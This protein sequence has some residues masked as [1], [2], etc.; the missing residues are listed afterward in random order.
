MKVTV[1]MRGNAMVVMLGG[2]IDHHSAEEIRTKI[3]NALRKS[4]T[5]ELI[6]NFADVSFMDS[7]GLGV[8][9]GRYKKVKAMGGVLRVEDVPKRIERI[10]RMAGVYTLIGNGGER[11]G[12]Q[13]GNE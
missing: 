8:I 7:S 1:E 2:E 12:R 11:Q 10:L 6:M 3:D 13:A 4:S 5:K 9:L